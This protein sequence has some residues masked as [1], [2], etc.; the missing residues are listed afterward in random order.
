[1]VKITDLS[2]FKK[3]YPNLQKQKY[4][5]QKILEEIIDSF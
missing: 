3:D 2:K 1:M 5:T 4:D